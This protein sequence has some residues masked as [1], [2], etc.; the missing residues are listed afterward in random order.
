MP[1]NEAVTITYAVSTDTF[2]FNFAT[3]SDTSVA[4]DGAAFIQTTGNSNHYICSNSN[5]RQETMFNLANATPSSIAA[6]QAL[7]SG[8]PLGGTEVTGTAEQGD[9]IVASSSTASAW[10]EGNAVV[11]SNAGSGNVATGDFNVV[12]GCGSGNSMLNSGSANSIISSVQCDMNTTSSYNSIIASSNTDVSSGSYAVAIGCDT[13]TITGVADSAVIIGSQDTDLRGANAHNNCVALACENVDSVPTQIIDNALVAATKNGTFSRTGAQSVIMGC[14]GGIYSFT[15]ARCGAIGSTEGTLS[16]TG[17]QNWLMGCAGAGTVISGAGTSRGQLFSNACEFTS[18]SGIRHVAVASLTCD[19]AGTGT[20]HVFL[21]S[22][23]CTKDATA[24]NSLAFI[25]SEDCDAT[26][27]AGLHA[28]IASFN[29]S[30]NATGGEYAMVASN[31]CNIDS[32]G[33][34]S[35]IVGAQS[36]DINSSRDENVIIGAI[37]AE[38]SG[39]AEHSVVIGGDGGQVTGRGAVL[40][41]GTRS[42]TLV[43][44]GGQVTANASVHICARSGGNAADIQSAGQGI[45]ISGIGTQWTNTTGGVV[46]HHSSGVTFWP[47]DDPATQTNSFVNWRSDGCEYGSTMPIAFAPQSEAITGNAHTVTVASSTVVVT[48]NGNHTG[49]VL[50]AGAYTGQMLTLRNASA[51]NTWAIGASVNFGGTGSLTL[52][53]NDMVLLI[54]DGSVWRGLSQIA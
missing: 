50:S 5:G 40:I 36:S 38:I 21:A 52:G 12:L 20:D 19:D 45:L 33:R 1:V 34:R 32:S 49:G 11:L 17:G 47:T 29:C 25:A 37:R 10:T 24:G 27:T 28:T 9:V 44:E 42:N 39:G 23:N 18:A 6:I 46:V 2:E 15:G 4:A 41:S 7:R 35:A 31:G 14:T 22:E 13:C 48:P 3:S 43:G 26:G 8:T 16:A 54:Y 51:S 53:T 30:S